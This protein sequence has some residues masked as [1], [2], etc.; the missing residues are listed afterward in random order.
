[1]VVFFMQDEPDQTP[2]TIEDMDGGEY[3]LDRLIAEKEV[4]GGLDCIVAGGFTDPDECYGTRP[5][6]SFLDGLTRP[7]AIDELPWTAPDPVSMAEEM[8][9]L[10]TTTLLET[11]DDTCDDIV[12]E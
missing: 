5:I 9:E 4:C 10:L 1:M 7:Y 3:V 12:I 6:R 2:V 11:I 8:T